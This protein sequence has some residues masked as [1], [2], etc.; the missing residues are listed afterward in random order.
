M[1]ALT[2]IEEHRSAAALQRLL[3]ERGPQIAAAILLAAIAI[4]AAF[5]LTGFLSRSSAA[6]AAANAP[7]ARPAVNPAVELATVAN[8]HLFGVASNGN[9]NAADA[10]QTTMPLVLAGVLATGDPKTGQA[11]IGANATSAK[12]YGVGDM[13]QGGARLSAVYMDRVLIERNGATEALSLPRTS[14]LATA[15]PPAATPISAARPPQPSTLQA[16]ALFNGLLRVQPVF[17][18]GKLSGYRVF[19]GPRGATVLTQLGLRSGDLITAI[20]G[21]QLDDATRSM[22]IVQTLGSS[23][24]ASVTVSRNG[25]LQELNLNLSNISLDAEN[26]NSG[27]DAAGAAGQN[28]GVPPAYRPGARF[29]ARG[30]PVLPGAPAGPADGDGAPGAAERPPTER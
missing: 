20:N 4:D 10:P 17:T 28:P 2:W 1:N 21:T 26:A 29:G 12:R 15:P 30:V 22:Q 16:G 6:P 27:T 25:A 8:A 5:V 24:S 13:I 9:A 23:D 11:I 7:M 14:S 19:P 3:Q 18:Q